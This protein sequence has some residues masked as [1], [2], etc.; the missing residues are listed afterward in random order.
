[1][2]RTRRKSYTKS[3]RF[4]RSCRNHGS[5]SYCVNTRTYQDRR[6]RAAAD[7]EL[8]TYYREGENHANT[9]K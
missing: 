3:K 6:D 7:R 2:S 9:S 8:R 1:M 5:C 4:D